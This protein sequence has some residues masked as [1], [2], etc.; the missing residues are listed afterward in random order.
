MNNSEQECKMNFQETNEIIGFT[1]AYSVIFVIG[2]TGN[3]III[4][5]IRYHGNMRK[6]AFN[7]LIVN[8]AVADILTALV[9]IPMAVVYLYV[10]TSWF[11]AGLFG[12]IT[13]KVLFFALPLTIGISIFTMTVIAIDRYRFT[14]SSIRNE[15]LSP[16]KVKISIACI[17]LLS[18]FVYVTELI[19]FTVTKDAKC[20]PD[21]NGLWS[22]E[23]ER[24]SHLIKFI[25]VYILPLVLMFIMYSIIIVRIRK[26]DLP[27]EAN[28]E[29]QKRRQ[30]QKKRSVH[31]MISVLVIF[32]LCWIPI[33]VFYFL[34]AYHQESFACIPVFWIM[35]CVLIGNMNCAINPLIYVIFIK[36]F[37]DGLRE[38]LKL[39]ET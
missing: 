26:W 14:S 1:A 34:N 15:S 23:K 8:M 25:L 31:M 28:E 33:Q 6:I 17:W 11:D 9:S 29:S 7:W 2:F 12:L 22:N 36:N 16:T 5:I 37:R 32:T 21:W 30:Q 10:E 19:K 20:R 4:Q 35:L 24:I 39:K 3:I 13:C 27:G 38:M 18:S